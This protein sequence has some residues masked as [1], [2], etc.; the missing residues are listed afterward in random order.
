MAK[1]NK[2]DEQEQEQG[3]GGVQMERKITNKALYGSK[4]QKPEKKSYLGTVFGIARG[5]Q[6][7]ESQNGPWTCLTGS[8]EARTHDG[9]RL[10]SPKCFLPDPLNSTLAEQLAGDDVESVQFATDVFIVPSDVPIG[11][12]YK[13]EM[14]V[15]P[16]GADP[17]ANLRQQ[18]LPSA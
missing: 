14:K 6:S 13:T 7:G 2:S 12:E 8:F 18:A 1:S 10:A 16:S 4:P 15:E 9:R 17:L 3:T 11:Y 5:V